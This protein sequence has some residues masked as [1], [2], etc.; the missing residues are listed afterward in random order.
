MSSNT[1]KFFVEKV[2][3]TKKENFYFILTLIISILINLIL[4]VCT[5]FFG[6]L[7]ILFYVAI[8]ALFVQGL[9]VGYIKQ[10]A[11]KITQDQFGDIYQKVSDI[12]F[13][14]HL[15]RTPEIY[16][17]QS[18]GILNAFATKFLFEDYVVLYSDI[19]ELAYQ[20]GEDAVNYVIAHELAHV[21]RNHLSKNRV[22]FW[23]LLIPFLGTAYSRACETTCD[24]IATYFVPEKPIEG[25]LALMA[26]KKLYK[27][28]NVKEMLSTAAKDYG[29]WA[30]LSEVNSTHPPLAKRVYNVLKV[31]NAILGTNSELVSG[32]EK[33]VLSTSY[34]VLIWLFVVCPYIFFFVIMIAAIMLQSTINS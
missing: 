33:F 26:G 21:K 29:F 34:K 20:E 28:V 18:D 1:S 31:Q 2:F 4:L 32:K 15:Q 24:N 5:F 22:L 13:K 8:I 25:L 11:V 23:G 14:L 10:N 16:L 3:V 19:L 17:M 27:K 9:A 30:W 12:S 6:Y 7:L